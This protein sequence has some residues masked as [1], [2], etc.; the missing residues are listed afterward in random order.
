MQLIAHT[1]VCVGDICFSIPY[2]HSPHLYTFGS[3][4]SEPKKKE[5][6][7]YFFTLKNRKMDDYTT[8]TPLPGIRPTCPLS[9]CCFA[10]TC[11][12]KPKGPQ[13]ARAGALAAWERH[14]V[15]LAGSTPTR[16]Q[17]ETANDCEW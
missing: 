16:R 10:G 14:A 15:H 3:L 8:L 4:N 2:T 11:Q 1:C 5:S 13:M 7:F 9:P 17:R 12:S 6:V